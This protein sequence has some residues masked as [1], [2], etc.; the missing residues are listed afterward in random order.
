MKKNRDNKLKVFKWT[1]AIFVG[2][3]LVSLLS[4]CY[5][6]VEGC[7][8][9]NA[10]NFDASA[11]ES[12]E[13][14]CTF[15]N[16]TINF[17]HQIN[18]TF[19]FYNTPYTFNGSEIIVFNSIRFYGSNFQMIQGGEAFGVIDSIELIISENGDSTNQFFEDNFTILDRST[20]PTTVDFGEAEGQGTFDSLRFTIGLDPLINTVMPDEVSESNH[21]L[22]PQTDSMWTAENGYIMGSFNMVVDTMANDTFTHQI[23]SPILPIDV[24]LPIN[25]TSSLGKDIELFLILNYNLLFEGIDFEAITANPDLLTSKIVENLPNSFF[26]SE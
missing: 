15:P 14:C 25:Y 5:E 21:P 6:K 10:T 12:C 8:D 23:F 16:F 4:S 11:D 24:A 22:G 18:D 1:R 20:R 3:V 9:T 13:D 17:S 7:L 26:I 19:L 2:L